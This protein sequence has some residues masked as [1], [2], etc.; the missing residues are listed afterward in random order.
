[1]KK[2]LNIIMATLLFLGL[3]ACATSKKGE[4]TTLK[5]ANDVQ[6][7]KINPEKTLVVYFSMPETNQAEDMNEEEEN[8]TVIINGEVIGNTQYF[9][10]II[11]EYT[12]GTLF[13]IEPEIPYPTDHDTLVDVAF[14]EQEENA[15]PVLKN[16]IENFEQYETI[17][18]GYPNWWG[19]MPMIL[20][21]FFDKYD[22]SGK[23][24]IPF[25]TH[26]GSGFSDTVTSIQE[27]ES[28]ATVLEQ[29]LSISRNDIENAK[30]EIIN[31]LDSLTLSVD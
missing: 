4:T 17:F 12:R 31:W 29:E 22:F 6:I 7:Q 2:A 20:Y 5:S 9:A 21:S 19:D 3:T 24:L 10:N 27:L 1:M 28:N 16:Q 15:R 25:N 26:G 18:I 8:S 30:T 14:A 11:Q 13:R 23:T